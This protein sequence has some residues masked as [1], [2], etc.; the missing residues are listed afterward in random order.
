MSDI[1]YAWYMKKSLAI[2]NRPAIDVAQD[3]N[4][5]SLLLLHHALGDRGCI[6]RLKTD[7]IAAYNA[8]VAKNVEPV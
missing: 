3:A 7:I 2:C 8:E 1:S 6:M 4:Q 5:T